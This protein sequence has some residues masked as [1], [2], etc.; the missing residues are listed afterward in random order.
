VPVTVAEQALVCAVEMEAGEQ[1]T[2]TDVMVGLTEMV[3]PPPPPPQPKA[4]IRPSDER[5]SA[6]LRFIRTPLTNQIFQGSYFASYS[7]TV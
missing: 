7:S 1:E 5:V 4:H 3:D 2:L 6:V